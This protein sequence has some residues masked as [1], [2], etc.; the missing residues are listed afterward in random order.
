MNMNLSENVNIEVPN[1][2][3]HRDS[4]DSYLYDNLV[5][6]HNYST[7]SI[8]REQGYENTLREAIDELKAEL[9]KLVS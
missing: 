6:D 5:E 2:L 9:D 1:Q 4:Y 7:L 8:F 3:E